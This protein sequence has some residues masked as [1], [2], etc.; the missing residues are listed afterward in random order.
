[1][2]SIAKLL[3]LTD[4]VLNQITN[5]KRKNDQRKWI[6][7]VALLLILLSLKLSI[8]ALKN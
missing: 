4:V 1:M 8:K 5:A 7:S 2:I 6:E 3:L